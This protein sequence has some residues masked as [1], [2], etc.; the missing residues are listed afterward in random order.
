MGHDGPDHGGGAVT[1]CRLCKALANDTVRTALGLKPLVALPVPVR[2][3]GP[4]SIWAYI[5]PPWR[6]LKAA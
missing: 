5:D 3:D 6:A 4:R 1:T 2:A